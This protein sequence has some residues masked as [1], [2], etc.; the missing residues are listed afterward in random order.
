[1][2]I[3]LLL[4]FPITL[5][6]GPNDCDDYIARHYKQDI[7]PISLRFA[8]RNLVGDIRFP[9]QAVSITIKNTGQVDMNE[10]AGDV[11]GFRSMKVRINGVLKTVRFRV[12]LDSG[13]TTVVRTTLPPKTLGHCQKAPVE[14]DVGH[15]VGQWGCQVWNNDLKT[16]KARIYNQFCRI[17]RRPFPRP[18]PLPRAP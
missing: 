8:N 14:V 15:T 13:R 9:H 12:P 16:L 4:L 10:R 17:I 6:A 2:K 1:M 3:L 7:V 11:G 5:L 18:Y